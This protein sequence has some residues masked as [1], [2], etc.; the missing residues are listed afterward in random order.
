MQVT[1]FASVVPV[2]DLQRSLRWYVDVLGFSKSFEYG[3]FY[4]GI[5]KGA[6]KLHLN[7]KG[8][9]PRGSASVYLFTDEVDRYY[10]EVTSRGAK[11]KEPPQSYDYGLRDFAVRDP[12]GNQIGF[13]CPVDEERPASTGA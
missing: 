5:E 7:A 2:T 3:G 10:A 1:G 12:D 8:E 11:A 4:A 6:A 9:M 13:G